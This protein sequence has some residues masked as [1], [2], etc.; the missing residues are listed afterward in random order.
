[1]YLQ[2]II[3][4]FALFAFSRAV[5][6]FKEN[7]I[8][9]KEFLFWTVVWGLVI[10]AVIL[11]DTLSYFS[12]LVGIGRGVD[13]VIYIS[14]IALFYLI[15]RLYVKLDIIEQDITK[16]TREISLKKP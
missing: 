13:L 8:T 12:D 16:I 4:I 1:M 5:L 7:E 11:P 6:R 14:L 15:F 3:I 10:V 9:W 2:I